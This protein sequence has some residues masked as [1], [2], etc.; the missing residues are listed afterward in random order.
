MFGWGDERA[1]RGE[2]RRKREERKEERR[3]RGERKMEVRA[4]LKRDFW[5]TRG[6]MLGGSREEREEIEMGGEEEE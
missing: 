5:L 3:K 2:E 1:L 6:Q 4:A